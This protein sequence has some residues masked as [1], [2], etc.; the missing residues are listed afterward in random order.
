MEELTYSPQLKCGDG[1]MGRLHEG[2]YTELSMR[3]LF[4]RS[5]RNYI[6]SKMIVWSQMQAYTLPH[7][8]VTGS[9][10]PRPLHLPAT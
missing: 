6:S 4:A 10:P 8:L 1:G 2:Y 7:S 9:P 3:V 5:T